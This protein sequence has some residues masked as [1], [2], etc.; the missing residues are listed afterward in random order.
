MSYPSRISAGETT[1][2]GPVGPLCRVMA[3]LWACATHN[4]GMFADAAR[5]ASHFDGYSTCAIVWRCHDH[6][7][8]GPPTIRIDDGVVMQWVPRRIDESDEAWAPYR[9]LEENQL[10]ALAGDR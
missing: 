5:L 4:I 9:G 1:P 2:W 3:G 10:R 8:E 7:P 6:G